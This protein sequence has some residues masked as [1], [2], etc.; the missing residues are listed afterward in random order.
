VAPTLTRCGDAAYSFFHYKEPRPISIEEMKILASFPQN[1]IFFGNYKDIKDR[2]GNAVPPN[3]MKIIVKNIVKEVL[4]K[5]DF[6]V[7]STFSGCGGSS[8]GYKMVGGK[9]LLAVEFNDNAVKTYK[10]NFPDTP[11]YHGDIHDLSVK[12]CKELADIK[13]G[14]LDILDGSP[15]CQGFSM[16]GKRIMD[17][18]RNSLF[19]EYIRLLRGLKPKVFV[20]ENVSGMVKGKMKL[21]FAEIMKKLKNSGYQVKCRLMN[22]KYYN[23]PQSRKR[24]IFI[25]V[26]NDLNIKPSHP[27]PQSKPIT[28]KK[29]IGDLKGN[30]REERFLP[31]IL[32]KI[33]KL[34]PDKWS[35]DIDIYKKIKGNTGGAIS[36]KWMGWNKICGTLPKSEISLTGI[37]HPERERYISLMEAKRISSFPDDFKFM[38]GRSKGIK[39]MGNS[40]PPNLMKAI[41]E[42]IKDNILLKIN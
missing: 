8:L 7:I 13:T 3:F 9:I 25:G 15:P 10:I 16:A 22:A 34:Q 24:L 18:P 1:F 19:Q 17:D 21:V 4:M 36:L 30:T 40:V 38:G 26:R 29:A 20:M 31:D 11:I 5:S 42:H 37:V 35:T 14:E 41:A 2:I 28:V 27:K 23:V 12:Q 39:R 32:K 33:A 6:N